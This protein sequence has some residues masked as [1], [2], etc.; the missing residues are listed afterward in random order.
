MISL[1]ERACSHSKLVWHA[2]N[3]NRSGSKYIVFKNVWKCI[4][5]FSIL[6]NI[7]CVITMM[8]MNP[9]MFL[10]NFTKLKKIISVELYYLCSVCDLMIVSTNLSGHWSLIKR[11]L[12]WREF[13][14]GM[15]DV[16]TP[17]KI[18]LHQVW[19]HRFL[20]TSINIYYILIIVVNLILSVYFWL[21]V[22]WVFNRMF[23]AFEDGWCYAKKPKVR[24]LLLK[25]LHP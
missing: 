18:L 6:P 4:S 5:V 13:S 25:D 3:Q 15:R 8:D 23:E 21:F 9:E 2:W 7:K 16:H 19:I 24:N 20:S 11:C 1:Y 17:V 14:N 22:G 12:A 10:L